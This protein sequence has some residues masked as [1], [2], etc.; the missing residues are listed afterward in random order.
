[1]WSKDGKTLPGALDLEY[2]P[3]PAEGGDCYGLS[4]SQMAAWITSFNNYY[5]ARWG[6]YPIIYTSTGWWNECVGTSFAT[7]N[8]LW[9]ASY[10]GATPGALPLGWSAQTVWQHSETTLDEDLFNGSTSQLAA[11][12]TAAKPA[13]GYPVSGPIKTK[14]LSASTTLGAPTAA[15][16]ARSDGGSYQVFRNGV[17]TYG[18]T[19][20]V[21]EFDGPIYTR[22]KALGAAAALSS[23]GYATSDG[24]SRVTF[25]KGG[26]LNNPGRGHSYIIRGAIWKKFQSIGGVAAMGL[27]KS[28]EVNG[29]GG[30]VRRM[31]WFEAGA[32]TWGVDGK[33]FAVRGAIYRAWSAAGSEKSRY[34]RPVSDEYA[35]GRQ[36]R[37]K[38]SNGYILAYQSGKVSAI[39]SR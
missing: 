32:I 10:G 19:T 21:H 23:L 3:T 30:G 24:N 6:R 4:R 11:F 36:I 15:M 38:F 27:P 31:N 9:I 8:P 20:G 1:G 5:G 17:I 28:D 2:N 34:G 33:T 25:Q 18:R 13:P 26:I 37:Q 16:V 35:S 39:R 14:Y 29:R 22:W 12:A 7:T